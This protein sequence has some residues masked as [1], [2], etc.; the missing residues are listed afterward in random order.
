HPAPT[1]AVFSA[2][3]DKDIAGMLAAMA[4]HIAHWHVGCLAEPADRVPDAADWMAALSAG[5]P[6]TA[7][8]LHASVPAAYAAALAE[9][10][11]ERILVFGSF[12]TL[13]AVMRLPR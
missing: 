12:H 13:E 1:V 5:L 6:E 11:G 9:N 8:S 7:F 4:P 2:L 10:R 3:K